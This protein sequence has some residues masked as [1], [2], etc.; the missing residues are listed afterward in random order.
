[1]SAAMMRP[2]VLTMAVGVHVLRAVTMRVGAEVDPV[3]PQPPQHVRAKADQHDADAESGV[4]LSARELAWIRSGDAPLASSLGID[5][6]ASFAW[7]EVDAQRALVLVRL[8]E[9]D[10]VAQPAEKR[11]I[12]RGGGVRREDDDAVVRFEDAE[13][14]TTSSRACASSTC[15]RSSTSRSAISGT[16]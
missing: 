6:S 1:M 4:S 7:A 13:R 12:D 14:R 11:R 5:S 8:G 15:S 9:L 10:A 3:A 16:T 2:L